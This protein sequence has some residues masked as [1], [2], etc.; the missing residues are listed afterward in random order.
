MKKRLTINHMALGSL[1]TRRKQYLSLAVGIVL[2]IFFV[3]SMMI[4]GQSMNYTMYQNYV[5]REGTQ[6][7]VICDAEEIDPQELI[8][9]GYAKRV[10]NVTVLG[11]AQ[12]EA[13]NDYRFLCVGE[14]DELTATMGGRPL[15][16]GRMPVASDEIAME[17]WSLRWIAPGAQIGDEITVT[18]KSLKVADQFL[19]KTTERK[20]S[21]VGV[22]A[23]KAR[24]HIYQSSASYLQ[25][26]SIIVAHQPIEV[27]AKP[28]IHRYVELEENVTLA[29]LQDYLSN[30]HAHYG[31]SGHVLPYVYSS[32]LE[33]DVILVAIEIIGLVLVLAACLGIVNAFTSLL[34]DRRSQIGMMRAVGATRKQ[35]RRIFGKEAFLIALVATPFAIGLSVLAMWGL[36]TASGLFEFYV[37]IPFIIVCALVSLICVMLSALMPL[38]GASGISPMQAIRETSL[39]RAKEKLTIKRQLQFDVPSL[40]AR[41]HISLYRN[42]QAGISA[43]VAVSL[44]IL[45]LLFIMVDSVVDLQRKQEV[46]PDYRIGDTYYSSD[47]IDDEANK[48]RLSDSDRARIKELP[49]VREVVGE[50]IISINVLMQEITNYIFSPLSDV[51][52]R[53]AY[54]LEPT[55]PRGMFDGNLDYRQLARDRYHLLLEQQPQDGKVLKTCLFVCDEAMLLRMSEYV[56]DGRIDIDAINRGEEVVVHAP[57]E[58]GFS[59]RDGYGDSHYI[60]SVHAKSGEKSK[61]TVA[62]DMFFAGDLLEMNYLYLT[63]PRVDAEYWSEVSDFTADVERWD[64]SARIGAVI[65][66]EKEATLWL[67]QGSVITTFAG[68]AAMGIPNN[69][70]N[71]LSVYLSETPSEEMGE[72]LYAELDN[73]SQYFP[74]VA[75]EDNIANTMDSRTSALQLIVCG[76][77][78]IILFFSICLSMVNNALT[79]RMR[80]EKR[81]I[82]TMRA[83]GASLDVIASS[84]FKQLMIMLC[85]GFAIGIVLSVAAIGLMLTVGGY[86]SLSLPIWILI[87]GELAFVALVLLASMLNLRSR[88]KGIMKSSIVDNIREL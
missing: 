12:V 49:L 74:E 87:G 7:A 60:D 54:L 52:S 67:N 51:P 68:L 64:G 86:G 35:I 29:T 62:N 38:W 5:R 19:T 4:I 50:R 83:V 23:D 9:L 10:G 45:S 82:G 6:D 39:L 17:Q 88:L 70:Y 79:N 71:S 48:P 16:K 78:V 36:C 80:S 3:S 57:P 43:I 14:L 28:A 66:Q 24:N 33:M 31:G 58:Q 75:V 76:A 1:R 46:K 42:K 18:L 37:T 56:Y 84:Y 63:N 13:F 69:G 44:V 40:L 26:P 59:E 30:I 41:R 27:G 73:I 21:L 25:I 47:F 55:D 72:Y 81:S 77:A 61:V 32:F 20:Y 11:E 65:S 8:D 2:A 85:S 53:Y 22:L 15:I 34:T